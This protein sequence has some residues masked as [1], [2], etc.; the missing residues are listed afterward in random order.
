MDDPVSASTDASQPHIRTYASDVAKLTGKPLAKNVQNVPAPLPVRPVVPAPPP[1]ATIVPKAPSTEE[2]REEVLA[3]LKAQATPPSRTAP[4]APPPADIIPKAPSTD[5]KREEVLARLRAKVGEPAVPPAPSIERASVMPGAPIIPEPVIRPAAT[6]EFTPPGIPQVSK[7][8]LGPSPIHTYK[9]DF[10]ERAKGTNASSISILAAE[11]DSKVKTPAAVKS[12]GRRLLPIIAAVVLIVLGG[13]SI[14]FAYRLITGR[15]SLPAEAVIPS[16][17]FADDH[18]ELS[19][20]SDELERGLIALESRNLTAGNVIVAFMTYATTTKDGTVQIPAEGGA[21]IAAFGL[22]APDLLLRNI[23]P[24]STVGVINAG[25]ETRPFFI[26]RVSSYERT[27]AGMLSWERTM[28]DDLALFYPQYPAVQ[29][30]GTSTSSSTAFAPQLPPHFIDAVVA[31][32]DVRELV[33]GANR[34]IFLY[35]YRDKETLVI[36]RNAD[37]FT[38]ILSRLAS[39][40]SH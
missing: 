16:L 39:T 26:L 12:S 31:N 1:P 36:A 7:A 8:P 10:S 33:D 32:H 20:T 3:R 28:G 37:A 14:F 35:G 21:L 18:A 9:T 25:S 17:I 30:T 19:G 34:V 27:F 24:E 2:K 6:P 22:P 4:E 15:P 23:E 38:E 29:S 5:E 40:Q 11:A 13:T